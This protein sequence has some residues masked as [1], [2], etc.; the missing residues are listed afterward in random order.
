M[1]CPAPT[2]G[3]HSPEDSA[4][5]IRLVVVLAISCSVP[6]FVECAAPFVAARKAPE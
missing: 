2:A 5:P 3:A 4:M 6:A 1:I